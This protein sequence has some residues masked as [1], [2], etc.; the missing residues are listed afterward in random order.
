ME[1][2]DLRENYR[3]DKRERRYNKSKKQWWI[4][5]VIGVIIPIVLC[6]ILCSPSKNITI[7]FYGVRQF[8]FVNRVIIEKADSVIKEHEDFMK[9]IMI[10]PYYMRW[11]YLWLYKPVYKLVGNDLVDIEGLKRGSV[12][13]FTSVQAVGCAEQ[14]G[15]YY[16]DSYN[17]LIDPCSAEESYISR[18][19]EEIDEKCGRCMSDRFQ[20]MEGIFITQGRESQEKREP[21]WNQIRDNPLTPISYAFLSFF[22]YK[23]DLGIEGDFKRYKMTGIMQ[24]VKVKDKSLVF[25]VKG[26]RNSLINSIEFKA[27]SRSRY[28]VKKVPKNCIANIFTLDEFN[29]EKS[30]SKFSKVINDKDFETYFLRWGR[31]IWLYVNPDI[32]KDKESRETIIYRARKYAEEFYQKLGLDLHSQSVRDFLIPSFWFNDGWV[33]GL[34][35]GLST[36]IMK[37]LGAKGFDVYRDTKGVEVDSIFIYYVGKPHTGAGNGLRRLG[38]ARNV[39][40]IPYIIKELGKTLGTKWY[41]EINTDRPEDIKSRGVVFIIFETDPVLEHP[42]FPLNK[43]FNFTRGEARMPEV[44]RAFTTFIEEMRNVWSGNRENG[45]EALNNSARVLQDAFAD[46]AALAPVCVDPIVVQIRKRI[47]IKHRMY[48]VDTKSVGLLYSTGFV[49]PIYW[50]LEAI[51]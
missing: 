44:S 45:R 34:D 43:I 33:H 48:R 20:S 50:R 23:P 32:Y 7:N 14:Q 28:S 8:D 11:A 12:D 18:K 17:S 10:R 22:R 27:F 1:D 13:L 39:K 31:F 19:I 29:S 38:R 41:F 3:D 5:G 24:L 26:G 37:D 16:F 36:G 42:L 40:N 4:L 9:S 46:E 49:E 35:L 6:V 51:R 2:R 25:K 21:T 47:K 30:I 15:L